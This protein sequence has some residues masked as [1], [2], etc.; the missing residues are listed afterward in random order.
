MLRLKSKCLKCQR[1]LTYLDVVKDSETRIKNVRCP[2]C[3]ALL[4]ACGIPGWLVLLYIFVPC[5][6][7]VPALYYVYMENL[8][9]GT[10]VALVSMIWLFLAGPLIFLN[11]PL[12]VEDEPEQDEDE[13]SP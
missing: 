2:E 12:Q 5:F 3:S 10:V 11:Y 13:P 4:T 7:V 6:S 8:V 1:V 9:A